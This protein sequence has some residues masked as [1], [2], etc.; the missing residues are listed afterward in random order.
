MRLHSG[1][2]LA[3]A[4]LVAVSL[5][6]AVLGQDAGAK[7]A[8]QP[9][10]G[11]ASDQATAARIKKLIE[12]LGDDQFAVREK[13]HAELLALGRS[14]VAALKE[15]RKSEDAEVRFRAETIL[16]T[17]QS[18]LPYLLENLKDKDPRIRVEAAGILERLESKAKPAIQALTEALKDKEETVRE[19]AVSA[20]LTIDPEN[21]AV[22]NAV[23]AKARV[24]GKYS[25]L[26][27]RLRVPQDKQ[28]YTDFKDYGHY[29]AIDYAGY[30]NL[31]VGYWVYVYSYWYIWGEMKQGK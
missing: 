15:A 9:K 21:K 2:S 13:A 27:R 20:L 19:A 24:Q 18:S 3:A 16:D 29:Q 28:S 7:T 31:L 14:A 8:N 6:R 12:Q 1:I 17:V 22:A 25:K 26:L 23:P 4:L 30:T 11:P 5:G 10:A